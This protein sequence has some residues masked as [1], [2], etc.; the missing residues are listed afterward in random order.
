MKKL[1]LSLVPIVDPTKLELLYEKFISKRLVH[2][3]NIETSEISKLRDFN[4][5]NLVCNSQPL[6]CVEGGK[7]RERMMQN[8]DNTWL[9]TIVSCYCKEVFH[10]HVGKHVL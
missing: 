2:L 8:E 10:V 6:C 1:H 7:E 4:T 5:S 9:F 3:P